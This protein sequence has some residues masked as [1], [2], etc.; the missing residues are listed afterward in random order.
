[1]V[2]KSSITLVS[3]L[4]CLTELDEFKLKHNTVVDNSTHN[5]KV[6]GLNPPIENYEKSP[7]Y[8]RKL[9][10]YSQHFIFFITYKY[11]K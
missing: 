10:Q 6:K 9:V 4:R 3:G 8:Y 1:M 5:P 7:Y 11:T 2:V